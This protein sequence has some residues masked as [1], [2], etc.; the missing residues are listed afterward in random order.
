VDAEILAKG[1]AAVEDFD[2]SQELVVQP[3]KS[4]NKLISIRLPM[5]TI[6]RLRAIA[7]KRGMGYQQLIKQYLADALTREQQRTWVLTSAAFQEGYPIGERCFVGSTAIQ[8]PAVESCVAD[9]SNYK[10]IVYGC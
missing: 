7:G 1:K 5:E 4:E 9:V 6:V 8:M 3:K 2:A 10:E